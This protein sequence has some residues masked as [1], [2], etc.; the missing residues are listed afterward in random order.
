M[1]NAHGLSRRVGAVVMGVG[2]LF[3]GA[4]SPVL[5]ADDADTSAGSDELRLPD[6]EFTGEVTE[7]SGDSASLEKA[8]YESADYYLNQLFVCQNRSFDTSN[9]TWA[10]LGVQRDP[11]TSA[12][13][14]MAYRQ[15]GVAGDKRAGFYG[16]V[17]NRLWFKEAHLAPSD[18]QFD[19]FFQDLYVQIKTTGEKDLEFLD[20]TT[21]VSEHA[22]AAKIMEDPTQYIRLQSAEPL[23]SYNGFDARNIRW[24][25]ISVPQAIRRIVMD[26]A[27]AQGVPR[28]YFMQGPGS[29]DQFSAEQIAQYDEIIGGLVSGSGVETAFSEWLKTHLSVEKVSPGEIVFKLADFGEDM[30]RQMSMLTATE[31]SEEEKEKYGVDFPYGAVYLGRLEHGYTD[32]DTGEIKY[33]SSGSH[34]DAQPTLFGMTRFDFGATPSRNKKNITYYE[35]AID[36]FRKGEPVAP[37]VVLDTYVSAFA[38]NESGTYEAQVNYYVDK[39]DLEAGK[40]AE[41]ETVGN[42]GASCG[43]EFVVE[44]EEVA[45][46]KPSSTSATSSSAVEPSASSV[47]PTTSEPVPSSAVSSSSAAPATSISEP[48]T[49]ESEPSSSAKP[50][51]TTSFAEPTPTTV[52]KEPEPSSAAASSS[53][54][55]T[56][57]PVPTESGSDAPAQP[58][59]VKPGVIVAEVSK[60]CDKSSK[61]TSAEKATAHTSDVRGVKKSGARVTTGGILRN[62]D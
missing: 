48:S 30:G 5:A 18:Y 22:L 56:P 12:L 41:G 3:G 39:A 53:L 9:T 60:H 13:T 23:D 27:I 21:P 54:V 28:E 52:V 51:S 62:M 43:G 32:P 42:Y 7:L 14:D 36:E 58:E 55:V 8:G 35:D 29:S 20:G 49:S 2:L 44:A 19:P 34:A 40:T 16:T 61:K 38:P 31:L 17:H 6:P 10:G 59:P 15:D 1:G 4:M 45:D 33:G 47:A 46:V 37:I 11:A 26:K 24:S 57:V 25:D 50:S